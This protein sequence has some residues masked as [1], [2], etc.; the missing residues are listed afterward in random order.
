MIAIGAGIALIGAAV[1][2]SMMKDQGGSS[3]ASVE[4]PTVDEDELS[5]KL[6][7]AYLDPPTHD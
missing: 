4:T 2:Y 5:D 6:K 1:A 3:S 7:R